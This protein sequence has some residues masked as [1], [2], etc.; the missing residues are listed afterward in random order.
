MEIVGGRSE[1][2]RR[3]SKNSA[4]GRQVLS[5]G[6][7]KARPKVDAIGKEAVIRAEAKIA[8]L[9]E[10][11]SGDRH[12]KGAV[13]LKGSMRYKIERTTDGNAPT[14][15]YR[16]ILYSDADVRHVMSLNYGARRHRID[17]RNGRTLKYPDIGTEWRAAMTT[18]PGEKRVAV[19]ARFSKSSRSGM[20]NTS[21]E[22][23]RYL[24]PGY[25]THPGVSASYFMQLAL[26]RAVAVH[27]RKSVMLERANA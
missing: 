19:K 16:V 12:K 14:F 27:L 20:Y 18:A 1:A 2:S 25:V 23:T 11:R 6:A 26:E 17:A 24:Y 4:F 21:G 22:G 13:P 9:Y 15:P 8:A 10:Q 7:R 3:L 5:Q